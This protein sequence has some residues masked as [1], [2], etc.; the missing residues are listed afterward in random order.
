M[1]RLAQAITKRVLGEKASASGKGLPPTID[2]KTAALKA[3]REKRDAV[4]IPLPAPKL[5]ALPAPAP[6][7]AS[8]QPKPAARAK[9]SEARATE[10]IA[11][12]RQPR[13]VLE[14]A[15]LYNAVIAETGW[16][17]AEI[18][19]RLEPN[20]RKEMGKAWD[21]VI[22]HVRLLALESEYQAAVVAGE[23]S[24]PASYELYRV[25]GT[26]RPQIFAPLKA[27]KSQSAIRELA[28]TL[29]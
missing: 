14:Q 16:F 26:I 2:R 21:S 19:R 27:R 17:A 24:L 9:V 3:A 15:K 8:D 10:L 25:N 1:A 23:I 5:P 22:H 13:G 6:K 12:L 29:T 20:L 4:V 18:A 7:P 11:S 28:K